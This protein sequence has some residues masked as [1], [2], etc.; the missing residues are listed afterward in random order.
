MCILEAYPN[1]NFFSLFLQG[2]AMTTVLFCFFCLAKLAKPHPSQTQA[3][4]GFNCLKF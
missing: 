4:V 1:Y 2:N 3:A